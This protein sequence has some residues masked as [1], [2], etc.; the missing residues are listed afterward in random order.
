MRFR[1]TEHESCSTG[2]DL[3]HNGFFLDAAGRQVYFSAFCWTTKR[4]TKREGWEYWNVAI[5]YRSARRD[6]SGSANDSV[7]VLPGHRWVNRNWVKFV[8]EDKKGQLCRDILWKVCKVHHF[9][10]QKTSVTIDLS[11]SIPPSALS[12]RM[13]NLRD[14]RWLA[15][16]HP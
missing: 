12:M 11:H 13:M 2:E 15:Y 10:Y 7:F 5:S 9:L 1:R 16:R 14:L 6:I 8:R 3:D 4:E